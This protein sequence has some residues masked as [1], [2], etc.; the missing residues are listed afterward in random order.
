MFH[1]NRNTQTKDLVSSEK[2]KLTSGLCIMYNCMLYIKKNRV[3]ES[4]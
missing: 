2:L 4:N 3:I 1:L